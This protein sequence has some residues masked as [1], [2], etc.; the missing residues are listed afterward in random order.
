[1][2][3]TVAFIP[4]DR[5]FG[6]VCA[7]KVRK[8]RAHFYGKVKKLGVLIVGRMLLASPKCLKINRV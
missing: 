3:V 8:L 6:N 5:L 1:M 2:N 4:L 7:P